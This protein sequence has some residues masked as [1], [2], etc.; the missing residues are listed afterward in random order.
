MRDR[1][2]ITELCDALNVS[3]SGYYKSLRAEPSER[4]KENR[5]ITQEMKQIHNEGFKRAYGSPR[6][7]VE[8]HKR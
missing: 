7:S 1:Y 8:L 4:M 5:R 2:T 3:R 6:M